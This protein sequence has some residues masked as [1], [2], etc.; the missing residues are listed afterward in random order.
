MTYKYIRL[1]CAILIHTLPF[2]ITEC[3][4]FGQIHASK[5]YKIKWE[6]SMNERTD[7]YLTQDSRQATFLKKGKHVSRF[8]IYLHYS[9]PKFIQSQLPAPNSIGFP[10][11][12]FV[13]T[14]SMLHGSNL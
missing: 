14:S 13:I 2:R 3:A 12:M 10:A 1:I 5:Y 4:I 9:F 6:K 8:F 11:F 7:I